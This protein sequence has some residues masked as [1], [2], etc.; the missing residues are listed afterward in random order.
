MN[1]PEARTWPEGMTADLKEPLTFPGH[2]AV[3]QVPAAGS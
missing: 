2:G 3:A 1:P